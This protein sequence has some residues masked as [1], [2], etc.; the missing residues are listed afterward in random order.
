M[1][2]AAAYEFEDVEPEDRDSSKDPATHTLQNA[3]SKLD[4]VDC[5][6]LRR[7]FTADCIHDRIWT[8][9]LYSDSSP[10]SGDETQGMIMDVLYK[11][12][13]TKR[14]TLPGTTL[15]YGMF[16]AVNKTVGL[17]HAMWLVA[18]P[19]AKVI[20][21]LCEKTVSVTTDMG[22]EVGTLMM[23]DF[24]DAFCEFMAGRPFETCNTLID[25]SRRWLPNAVRVGGWSHGW[26]NVMK[27]GSAKCSQWPQRL[28]QMQVLTS[29]LRNETWRTY[30]AK[31]CKQIGAAGVEMDA[32]THTV[33]GFAKWRYETI[34]NVM[35]DLLK[36]RSACRHVRAEWFQNPQD[37]EQL[38]E[39]LAACA[40][41]EL[42][43]FMEVAHREVFAKCEGCRHWGMVCDCPE[44]QEKRR[45][46]G[47][48]HVPCWWNSRRLQ[49]AWEFITDRC[50]EFQH[51]SRTITRAEC[52]GNGRLQRDIKAMLLHT[53]QIS[54]LEVL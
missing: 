46:G 21:Y 1:G 38:K 49:G 26:G 9:S 54:P 12:R 6:L 40:D 24:T 37:K 7:E 50:R 51:R 8:I 3:L 35:R 52:A 14:L 13:S 43:D 4:I 20:R 15:A 36:L 47:V 5:L 29:F 34:G 27:T 39:C 30:I 19:S 25:Y 18:G 11:D 10:V 23:P 28:S 53:N 41:E 32:L 42:W 48:V 33:H 44:H 22:T 2:A 45:E 16:D 31:S 17:M